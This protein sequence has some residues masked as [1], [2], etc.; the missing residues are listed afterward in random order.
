MWKIEKLTILFTR[1]G[2]KLHIMVAN[3]KKFWSHRENCVDHTLLPMQSVIFV[4]HH[5]MQFETITLWLNSAVFI[6]FLY[7]AT[8]PKQGYRWCFQQYYRFFHRIL[9]HSKSWRAYTLYH[10][11]KSYS[12]FAEFDWMVCFMASKKLPSLTNIN[13]HTF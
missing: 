12:Y 2:F 7:I 3:E 9:H 10:W 1:D 5:D 11:F 6:S 4:R 8:K 13:C